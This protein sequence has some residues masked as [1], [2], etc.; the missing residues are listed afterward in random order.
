MVPPLPVLYGLV[1][2]GGHSTRMGQDKALIEYGDGPQVLA[3]WRRVQPCV[4]ECFVSLRADQREEP[5]R[6]AL[7]ALV[8]AVDGIGAAAG[9]LAAHAAR[10][11]AAWLVVACDLPLLQASTLSTLVHARDGRHAAIAYRGDQDG[12]PEP[13]CA[14]WEPEALQALARASGS[15]RHG[16]RNA[17]A[18]VSTLLLATPADQSLRNINTPQERAE[19][20][21]ESRRTATRPPPLKMGD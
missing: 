16:L 13:L 20:Q 1:L 19:L 9:L 15:G 7:P 14:V 6:S 11:E 4:R 5:V 21:A 2:T 17:L 12:Q 3:A 8:D 10:P 18:Q